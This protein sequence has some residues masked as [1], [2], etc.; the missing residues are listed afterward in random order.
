MND[1]CENLPVKG[2]YRH[3][4]GNLYE[5]LCIATDSET[6]E[7]KVVYRALY[8]DGGIWVRP[9]SMWSEE[10]TLPDGTKTKRFTLAEETERQ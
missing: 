8:G 2:V 6:L 9:L 4:K 1:A 3:F 5:L 7:K 10:I